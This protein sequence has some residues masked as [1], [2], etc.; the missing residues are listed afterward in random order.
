MQ[1]SVSLLPSEQTVDSTIQLAVVIDVLRA[2]SVMTTALANGAQKFVTCQSIDEAKSLANS[3]DSRP[4]LCGE[5][6]CKRID[7]FDLGNSPAEYSADVVKDRSL[8]LTTTNGT[9]AIEAGR[10]VP[11][12]I[13]ASFLN[14]SAV[15]SNVCR[16]DSVHLICAGTNGR[17]T[18]EDVL[19]AGAIIGQAERAKELTLAND[20]ATLARELWQSWFAGAVPT[21]QSL[22]SRLGQTQGGRNLIRVGYDRD[23]DLCAAIDSMDVVPVRTGVGP[24]EFLLAEV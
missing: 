6:E 7:G 5:R 10:D 23:L 8:V 2:T 13:V 24:S 3:T 21:Q 17:V 11:K 16:F 18:T 19:L 15:V 12:M 4:L 9:N 14:L 22:A 20:D 1:V